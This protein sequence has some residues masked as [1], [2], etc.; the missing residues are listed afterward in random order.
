MAHTGLFKV[1]AAGLTA[2][3]AVIL[4]FAA[5]TTGAGAQEPLHG[6]CGP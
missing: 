5:F 4:L 6:R 2:I 3:L 1:W